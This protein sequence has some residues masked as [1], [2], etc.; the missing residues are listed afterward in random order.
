[1]L[2]LYIFAIFIPN[3]PFIST[4]WKFFEDSLH[5]NQIFLRYQTL[6]VFIWICFEENRPISILFWKKD[7]KKNLFGVHFFVNFY[8]AA[9]PWLFFKKTFFG[10]LSYD[11]LHEFLKHGPMFYQLKFL[12]VCPSLCV[13]VHF[14]GTVQTFFF[15]HFPKLDVE[16]F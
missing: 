7:L 14:W 5:N 9:S 3:I 1:M 8:L 12:S 13:S 2:G 11:L 10:K 16:C 6:V 4:R 15:P